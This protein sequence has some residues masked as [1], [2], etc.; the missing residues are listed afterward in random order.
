MLVTSPGTHKRKLGKATDPWSYLTAG[1]IWLCTESL[2]ML[3]CCTHRVSQQPRLGRKP[4]KF[5]K[6]NLKFPL[7]TLYGYTKACDGLVNAAAA[8]RVSRLFG[9]CSCLYWG[10][11]VHTFL[12]HTLYDQDHDGALLLPMGNVL[13]NLFTQKLLPRNTAVSA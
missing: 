8:S 7:Q 4:R 1:I 2:V 6:Q 13:P 9:L 10:F 12:V 11:L 5:Q 3:C